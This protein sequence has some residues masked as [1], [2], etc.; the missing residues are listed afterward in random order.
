MTVMTHIKALQAGHSSQGTSEPITP[1]PDFRGP[2]RADLADTIAQL[3]FEIEK[4]KFAPLG[5]STSATWV[6]PARP[7][8]V[9]KFS[10]GM[11]SDDRPDE[12]IDSGM[13]TLQSRGTSPALESMLPDTM[14]DWGTVG[15]DASTP[16]LG[17]NHRFRPNNGVRPR[18]FGHDMLTRYLMH[19]RRR[20]DQPGPDFI[21][22][23]QADRTADL[24]VTV[25]RLQSDVHTL[26]LASPAPLAPA[27]W[28]QPARRHI[29]EYGLVSALNDHYGSL[30]RL[31]GIPTQIQKDCPYSR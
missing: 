20:Q 19:H 3:Q 12:T 16:V 25:A 21:S 17:Q 8:L 31:A 1:V 15:V 28:T 27:T 22:Q 13:G 14:M 23:Q 29:H 11:K 10:L 30:G 18:L 7:G 6:P 5:P 4:F 9:P 24:L 2:Q 26:K